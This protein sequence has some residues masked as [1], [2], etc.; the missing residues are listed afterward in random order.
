[1]V[2]L[3]H[4]ISKAA[5][6]AEL[7]AKYGLT[8]QQLQQYDKLLAERN[9]A[10]EVVNDNPD[11]GKEEYSKRIKAITNNFEQEMS[12]L[13][14][15]DQYNKWLG[16]INATREQNDRNRKELRAKI[17]QINESDI[18]QL[19]KQE[20]IAVAEAEY[21][22]KAAVINGSQKEGEHKLEMWHTHNTMALQEK[23][24]VHMSLNQAKQLQSLTSEKNRKIVAL[25]S[26]NLPKARYRIEH[27]D[28]LAE[29]DASVQKLL[30]GQKFAQWDKNRKTT[31]D[32]ILQKQ[33][34]M[35]SEQITQYKKLLNAQAI[36][37]YKVS[38]SKLSKAE[39]DAKHQEIEAEYAAKFKE[40]LTADQYRKIAADKAYSEQTEKHIQNK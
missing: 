29:Y 6:H 36:D 21:V 40:I 7:T 22:R 24:N 34:G 8:L 17:N 12:S 10:F 37:R 11:L 20:Q 23:K 33:Y 26:Q 28:I 39:R 19:Q 13:M 31:L 27:E 25:K 4:N 15:Q 35:T 5:E 32:R 3:F 16:D 18:P 14:T 30:G 9:A 2:K 38:H 1:M